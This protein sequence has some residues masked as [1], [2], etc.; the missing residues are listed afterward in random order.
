[1]NEIIVTLQA[2]DFDFRHFPMDHQSF[3][4]RI[5][6]DAPTDFIQFEP[7]TGANGMGPKLGEEE[8]IVSGTWTEVD[9]ITGLS[10]L[11]SSRFSLGFS[12]E[13]HMLY[14]WARIFFPLILLIG[15]SWASLFLKE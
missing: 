15:I 2:P 10:G 8:W 1:M 4:F 7:L 11:P 5:L 13:R 9:E 12:V 14:Y 6:A 3:Y